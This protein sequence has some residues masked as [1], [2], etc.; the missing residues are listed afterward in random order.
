[1]AE[2]MAESPASSQGRRAEKRIKLVGRNPV[3]S[4]PKEFLDNDIEKMEYHI[5]NLEVIDL[6]SRI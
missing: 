4:P 6:S 2:N 3:G 1:M 5:H